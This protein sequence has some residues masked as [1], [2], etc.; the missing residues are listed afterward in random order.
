MKMT[1]IAGAIATPDSTVGTNAP[2]LCWAIINDLIK[3]KA[4]NH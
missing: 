3:N 4:M 2:T 1:M